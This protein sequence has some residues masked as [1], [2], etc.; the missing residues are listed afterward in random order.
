VIFEK[1]SSLKEIGPQA[2]W[3]SGVKAIEIPENVKF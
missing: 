1:N 2:F 3:H